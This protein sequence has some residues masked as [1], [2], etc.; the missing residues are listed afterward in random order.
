MTV[1]ET[2]T[3]QLAI[4]QRDQALGRLDAIRALCV[5]RPTDPELAD[6]ILRAA[7]PDP[8]QGRELQEDNA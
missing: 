3:L 7:G 5:T 8:M 4:Q 1:Y 6:R 2:V